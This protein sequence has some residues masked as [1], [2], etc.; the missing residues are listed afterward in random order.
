MIDI[1]EIKPGDKVRVRMCTHSMQVAG[2]PPVEFETVAYQ[3]A[4]TNMP[5]LVAGYRLGHPAC[6]LEVLEHTPAIM[7]ESELLVQDSNGRIWARTGTVWWES[8]ENVLFGR[9]TEELNET[10]GPCTPYNP[11]SECA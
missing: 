2:V 9:T 5:M 1:A 4:H 3:D 7:W 8:V 10:Y 11:D 6:H